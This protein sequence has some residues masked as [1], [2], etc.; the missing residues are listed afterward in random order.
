MDQ[1]MT[2]ATL[3]TTLGSP[4]LRSS[5]AQ[6]CERLL[7]I[8]Q[9]FQQQPITPQATCDFEKKLPSIFGKSVANFSNTPSTTWNPPLCSNLLHA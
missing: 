2:S 7:E 8:V 6:Y 9:A 3:L 5:L 4:L 1:S